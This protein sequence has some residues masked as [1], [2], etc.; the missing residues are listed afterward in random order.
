MNTLIAEHTENGDMVFDIHQRLA[1]D[2]VFF[3]SQIIDDKFA[4][5]MVANLI[6]KNAESKTEKITLFINS[7]GG[8]ISSILSIY[9][10]MQLI[11]CPIQTIAIGD[12]NSES[13]IILAGG[14]PGL[15]CA[16][17]NAVMKP[18]EITFYNMGSSSM[19][20]SKITLDLYRF[21]NKKMLE[22]IAKHS[23]K[24]VAVLTKDIK[25]GI[26]FTADKAKKYGL[27]DKVIK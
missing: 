21:F 5:D 9:D 12:V 18:E 25:N 22:I 23:G 26:F 13:L 3:I 15:R 17:K 27:I 1:A 24:T 10:I 8:N 7:E 2:R 14:T 11:E 16:S 19:D 6:L 4:S 20:D